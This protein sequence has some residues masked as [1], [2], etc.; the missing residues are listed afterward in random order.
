MYV[1]PD[2]RGQGL[3]NKLMQALMDWA[4]TRG[5]Y[6]FYLDVYAGSQSAISAYEKLG[7]EASL[8]EMK[9]NI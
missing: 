1:N 7:F 9:L 6:D 4:T 3:N 5:I 8:V 2:Y